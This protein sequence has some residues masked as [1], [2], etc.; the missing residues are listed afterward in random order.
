MESKLRTPTAEFGMHSVSQRKRFNVFCERK[1]QFHCS[2][3][4]RRQSQDRLETLRSPWARK[5]VQITSGKWRLQV[6][7]I[8]FWYRILH[9]TFPGSPV[10]ALVLEAFVCAVTGAKTFAAGIATSGTGCS[11]HKPSL[12]QA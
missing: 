4:A 1:I 10:R 7:Q 6:R 12:L 9:R 5:V 3:W 11:L 2:S 8:L